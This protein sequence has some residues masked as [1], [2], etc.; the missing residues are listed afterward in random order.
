[1]GLSTPSDG[2]RSAGN[3]SQRLRYSRLE[4]E[5][6]PDTDCRHDLYSTCP[7]DTRNT[8]YITDGVGIYLNL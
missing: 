7:V 8:S 1:M 4:S 3:N 6:G 5:I 2:D